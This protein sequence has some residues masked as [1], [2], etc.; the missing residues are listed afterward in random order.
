MFFPGDTMG[1][2]AIFLTH[3]WVWNMKCTDNTTFYY[4]SAQKF[5]AILAHHHSVSKKLVRLA[6]RRLER[7]VKTKK[8]IYQL[9][10][11][12]RLRVVNRSSIKAA[13][14]RASDASSAYHHNFNC[15]V[16][17]SNNSNSCGSSNSAL[18]NKD[19]KGTNDS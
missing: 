17:E 3:K 18:K 1:E 6:G 15:L 16:P 5:T 7:I 11:K 14:I 9:R 13:R 12:R 19:Q 2:I 10:E 4:V 8:K